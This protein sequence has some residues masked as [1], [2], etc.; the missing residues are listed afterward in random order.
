[1]QRHEVLCTGEMREEKKE[2]VDGGRRVKEKSLLCV[3]ERWPICDPCVYKRERREM[4]ERGP[5]AANEAAERENV[6]CANDVRAAKL[7]K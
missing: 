7:E 3:Q 4:S 5:E 1:M 2:K 6:Q